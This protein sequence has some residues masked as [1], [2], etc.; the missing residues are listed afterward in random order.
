MSMFLDTSAI[1]WDRFGGLEACEAKWSGDKDF[2]E[3]FNAAFF[4]SNGMDYDPAKDSNVEAWVTA[5]DRAPYTDMAAVLLP[6]LAKQHDLAGVE[7]S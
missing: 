2:W 6:R 5:K 3:S 7:I 1:V 4:S